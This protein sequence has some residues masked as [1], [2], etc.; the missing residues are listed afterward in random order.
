MIACGDTSFRADT[1]DDL[2]SIYQAHLDQGPFGDITALDRLKCARWKFQA[3]EQIDANSLRRIK[4][5]HPVLIVNGIYD[6]VTPLIS[7]WEVSA[8]FPGSRVVIHEGVGVSL[9]SRFNSSPD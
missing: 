4:T 8:R 1:P 7:A 2:F 9:S 5:K 6:P 3:A